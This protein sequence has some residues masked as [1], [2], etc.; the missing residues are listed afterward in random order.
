MTL[1]QT[2]IEVSDEFLTREPLMHVLAQFGHVAALKPTRN[3]THDVTIEEKYSRQ[4]P[5]TIGERS[6]IE[7]STSYCAE[8]GT[9][10]QSSV[11]KPVTP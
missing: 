2:I 7:T 11:I 3:R 4:W 6:T 10:V 5:Q 9:Y 8:T 1:R